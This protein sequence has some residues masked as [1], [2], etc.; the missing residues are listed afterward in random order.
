MTNAAVA[1]NESAYQTGKNQTKKYRAQ[2]FGDYTR[3]VDSVIPVALL[4]F[5]APR[6]PPPLARNATDEAKGLYSA[7]TGCDPSFDREEGSLYY[8]GQT[9]VRGKPF[10]NLEEDNIVSLRT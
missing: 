1:A 10:H 3:D 2:F 9:S 7:K 4:Q 5:N 8:T 6:C